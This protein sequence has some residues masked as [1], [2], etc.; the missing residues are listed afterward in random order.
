[1]GIFTFCDERTPLYLNFSLFA[2]NDWQ[3]AFLF[4]TFAQG[5]LINK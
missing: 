5:K 4:I 1:M 3:S 2:L